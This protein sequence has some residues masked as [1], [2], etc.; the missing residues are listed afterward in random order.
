MAYI[1]LFAAFLLNGVANVLLKLGSV[2]G[3][4]L[5]GNVPTLIVSNWQ[6][7]LGLFL[8][9]AN[10]IFYF[11]ALRALPLSIAYP[12]MVAM[13]FLIINGY[14]FFGLREGITTLQLGGYALI[15][16]G[17]TLV[18]YRAG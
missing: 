2:K 17:L 18:V 16:I 6:F 3:L 11:L 10:V 9:A 8:F 1:Y 7:L 14:A 12:V 4:S 15:V 5:S 13:S